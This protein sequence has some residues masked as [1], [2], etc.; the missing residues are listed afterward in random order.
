MTDDSGS[1]TESP[2]DQILSDLWNAGSHLAHAAGEAAESVAHVG[3]AG[4]GLVTGDTE[5]AA[6]QWREA[7][8]D[9]SNAGSFLGWA[10]SETRHAWD[11]TADEAHS[12]WA[13]LDH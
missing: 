7:G 4:F 1:H 5:G 11:V 10:G 12:A 8:D 13:N 2:G 6:H 9:L 3:A